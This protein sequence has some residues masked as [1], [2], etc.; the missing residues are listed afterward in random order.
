MWCATN[1]EFARFLGFAYRSLKEVVTALELCERIDPSLPRDP[2]HDLIEEENHISK[3]IYALMRK[4]DPGIPARIDPQRFHIVTTLADAILWT[5]D[6]FDQNYR[7]SGGPPWAHR[8]YYQI[9]GT[10]HAPAT[11]K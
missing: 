1:T 11:T 2:T 3:M 10:A 7:I 4:V 9:E 5:N 8:D 6:I